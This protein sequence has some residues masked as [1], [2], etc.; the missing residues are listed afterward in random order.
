MQRQGN[1]GQR[2]AAHRTFLQFFC[3]LVYK[4]AMKKP[5]DEIPTTVYAGLTSTDHTLF[6]Q[7]AEAELEKMALRLHYAPKVFT[8]AKI[9]GGDE[10]GSKVVYVWGHEKQTIRVPVPDDSPAA[11]TQALEA[12]LKEHPIYK[13]RFEQVDSEQSDSDT[14]D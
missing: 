12:K 13:A 1:G 5:D 9:L 10:S 4:G 7:A 8:L 11:F 2:A 14:S 3:C 6:D